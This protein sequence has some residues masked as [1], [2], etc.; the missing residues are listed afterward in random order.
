MK[1]SKKLIISMLALTLG[2]L[3]LAE[4]GI[5][6]VIANLQDTSRQMYGSLRSDAEQTIEEGLYSTDSDSLGLIAEL[7]TE[8]TDSRLRF[9][10]D[11]VAQSAE[12]AERLYASPAAYAN[13]AYAPVHL[14]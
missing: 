7:Q 12:Y 9:V 5:F 6:A 1:I 2:T 10:E 11:A 13:S 4:A 3:L 14:S 8:V